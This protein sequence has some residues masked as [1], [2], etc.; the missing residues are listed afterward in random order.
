MVIIKV[1][2][3]AL[4]LLG[5]IIV[6][7]LYCYCGVVVVSVVYGVLVSVDCCDDIIDVVDVDLLCSCC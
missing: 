7:C 6:C 5:C 4:A 3:L 2:Q 1:D